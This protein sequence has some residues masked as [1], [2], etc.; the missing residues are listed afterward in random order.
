M[1]HKIVFFF[2]FLPGHAIL[3]QCLISKSLPAQ[4]APP[5]LGG[6]LVHVLLRLCVPLPQVRLHGL[7]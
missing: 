1:I 6:G 5:F 4:E 7:Q 2:L 3:L